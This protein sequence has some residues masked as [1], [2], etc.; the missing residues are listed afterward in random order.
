MVLLCFTACKKDA[1]ENETAEQIWLGDY[2]FV[3]EETGEIKTATVVSE[4]ESSVLIKF[5]SVRSNDEFCP[6]FKSSSGKYAIYNSEDRCIKFNLKSGNTVIA[7]DDIRINK[8]VKRNENWSGKYKLAEEEMPSVKYGDDKWNGE[9]KNS[10]NDFEIS[11]YAI[12]ESTI[13][14]NYIYDS[15]KGKEKANVVCN[16][17]DDTNCGYYDDNREISVSLKK[18]DKEIEITDLYKNKQE[19]EKS[20]NLSGTYTKN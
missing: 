11:V 4:D 14:I 10:E 18:G 19:E 6:E 5:Q 13:L 8:D 17:Q 9:Y 3:D 20:I 15:E 16:L 1:D 12:T 7:V 2:M